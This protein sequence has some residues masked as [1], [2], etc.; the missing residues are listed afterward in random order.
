MRYSL[1]QALTALTCLCTLFASLVNFGV[2]VTALIAV[3]VVLWGTTIVR[4]RASWPELSPLQKATAV[5]SWSVALLL[6]TSIT[7]AVAVDT[8]RGPAYVSW[9]IR[10]RLNDDPRFAT[11]RV[12]HRHNRK[13]RHVDIFG[14][15]ATE[16]DATA[17]AELVAP[18]EDGSIYFFN[19]NIRIRSTDRTIDESEWFPDEP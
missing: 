14:D 9:Q 19:V 1:S 2:P 7:V 13:L 6:L 15:L 16:A 4:T 8:Y 3:T 11:V 17:L 5:S 18:F 10:E 12:D